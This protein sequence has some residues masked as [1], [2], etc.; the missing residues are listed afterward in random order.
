M[1]ASRGARVPLRRRDVHQING[2][3][4][5]SRSRTRD[6]YFTAIAERLKR[7]HD[8]QEGRQQPQPEPQESVQAQPASL[9]RSVQ[10]QPQQMV[11]SV[12]MTMHSEL[13]DPVQVQVRWRHGPQRPLMVARMIAT[14][15]CAYI[16][17]CI[18]GHT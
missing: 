5:L 14:M 15:C 4:L 16:C 11:P 12:Q 10:H 7:V 6:A 1:L 17:L 8:T 13:R 18:R 9:A 3:R 2:L